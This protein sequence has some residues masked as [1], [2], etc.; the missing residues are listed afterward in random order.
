MGKRANMGSDMGWNVESL[1]WEKVQ[2]RSGCGARRQHAFI[3]I[4]QGATTESGNGGGI[5]SGNEGIGEATTQRRSGE[6]SGE[7]QVVHGAMVGTQGTLSKAPKRDGKSVGASRD[8]W[9]ASRPQR[10]QKL[11]WLSRGA[12]RRQSPT[13]AAHNGIRNSIGLSP[14]AQR[15]PSTTQAAHNGA[16]HKIGFRAARNAGRARRKPPTTASKTRLAFAR[17]ATPAEPDASR[18]HRRQKLDC[19]SRGAQ[20]KPSPTQAAHNGTS[21]WI[22]FRAAPTPA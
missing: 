21:N 2:A 18:P 13:Q 16:R 3:C 17:R 7:P 6:T 1:V 9:D 15:R 8:V 22:G 10:H 12:Q 5:D 14:G 4:G 19:V 20:R 11:D